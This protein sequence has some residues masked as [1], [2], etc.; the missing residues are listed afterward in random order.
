MYNMP[1]TAHRNLRSATSN[2]VKRVTGIPIT[3]A[4]PWHLVGAPQTF[5][6][7]LSE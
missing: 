7:W 1:D 3:Q 5:A 4:L 6:K 2:L